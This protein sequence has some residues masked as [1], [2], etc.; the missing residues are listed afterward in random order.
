MKHQN[1]RVSTNVHQNHG[2]GPEQWVLL[3][4]WFDQ[5]LKGV[6][7][8]IPI[9][10]PSTFQVNGQQATF[11][12]TP[13][14]PPR[15]VD[16]EIY[17]S[18][19]PNSRTR[20]WNRAEATRSGP[21]WSVDLTVHQDLPLYVFALCRYRLPQ[22]VPLEHGEASTFTLNSQEH[23]LV[24]EKVELAALATL[25]KTRTVFEDFQNGIQDWSTR[26]QRTIRTYKFQSP[27]LDRSNGKKLSL[28]IDPQGKRLSVRLSVGSGFLRREDNLGNFWWVKSVQGQ[29]PQEI[30]IGREDFKSDSGKTLEWSKIATLEITLVDQATQAKLD[31]TSPEGHAVLQL[32]K[33]VDGDE[34]G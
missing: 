32:I 13:A 24:P 21:T 17:Y 22:A 7:Q 26:D 2:P 33:L 16:T 28:T 6:D 3:N 31:L 10:P 19:D 25:P 8:Q 11:T 18:Y 9:T 27:D 14:D 34:S 1:W 12:V 29:G 5:Y 30:L 15:L 4:K 20:F 23:M